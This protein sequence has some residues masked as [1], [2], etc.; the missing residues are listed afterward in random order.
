LEAAQ[1]PKEAKMKLSTRLAAGALVASLAAVP[2]TAEAKPA[3][4]AKVRAEV[5]VADKSLDRVVS[6]VQRNRD[7]AASKQLAKYRKQL[8]RAD[9]QLRKLRSS[10]TDTAGAKSYGSAARM[11]GSI[12]NECVDS[13]AKIVD[14]AAGNPQE[15]IARAITACLAARERVLDT[16]TQLISQVPVEAQPYLAKVI[17]MLSSDGQDEIA[18]LTGVL[19][20]PGLP[21][22][23]ASI[24]TTALEMAT[25]AIDD[26]MTRLNGI[27]DVVPPEVR[28]LVQSTLGMVTGIMDSVMGMVKGLLTG[29]FGGTPT[30]PGTPGTGAGGLGGLFGGGGLPGLNLLQGIFGQ[31]FPTNLIP[32]NLPFNVSGF[33]F[34]TR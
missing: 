18:N 15:A 7:R 11:V 34:A 20:N 30:N 33:G 31:G 32:I 17:A 26:A 2:A 6:L 25:Q 28:P 23:V 4:A 13:L 5:R 8:R 10:A 9:G 22:D 29:L 16:L 3:S 14:E 27:L 24:L 1:L 12:S 19:D 21:T